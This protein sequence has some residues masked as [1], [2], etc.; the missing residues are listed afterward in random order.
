VRTLINGLHTR[1]SRTVVEQA[2]IAG[3]LN[4]DIL[5]NP[6]R[7]IEAATYVA[8]RLDLISEETERG[9][10]GRADPSNE[11]VG[12]LFFERTVRG[13]KEVVTLDAALL[14]SADARALDRYAARL[15][16]VYGQQPV[17]RRRE[18]REIVTG[19]NALLDAVFAT[20]R[21]G[22]SIQRYKGLGEMNA[23]QLWETTLDPNVRTLLQVK[24]PDATNADSL[25]SRLMGDEVEPR[26][27]FIQDNA[28][29]VANLDV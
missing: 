26:R 20:G 18:T 27:E 10:E 4:A 22:L 2:V 11:G 9:W 25:F 14:G 12:G 5:N 7:A 13:V 28:L 15:R 19:P 21:K 3:A 29:S 8:E 6:A 16:E 1:Y 24:V 17:L 23:E